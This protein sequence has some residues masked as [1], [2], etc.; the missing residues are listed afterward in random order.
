VAI[1]QSEINNVVQSFS[2]NGATAAASAGPQQPSGP[3]SKRE[4]LEELAQ[5]LAEG[6][7][8]DTEHTEGRAKIISD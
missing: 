1:T 8:T 5:L 6:I 3:K 7:I 4:R 2:L